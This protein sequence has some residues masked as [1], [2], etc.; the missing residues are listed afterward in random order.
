[1]K[2]AIVPSAKAKWEIREVKKPVVGPNQVLIKI[3]ASGLCYTDVHQTNGH[4]PGEFPRTLGHEP[5]G[6]IVELGIGVVNRK[7]GDR[8]GVPWI[9]ATCGRCEWCLSNRPMFCSNQIAT[10]M[11]LPGGHAEFMLAY[12]DATMLIPDNVSFEQA[13]PIFCAGYTVWSGL[14]WSDP[15]PHERIAVLGIGGLGHL[16]V[17][18]AKAAG[19]D[20][21]AIS[22]SSDK[23]KLI[24][25]LGADEIVRSGAELAK[26]GG[27]DIVLSTTNSNQAMVDSI[28]GLR[29]DGRFVAMG[30]DEKPLQI[31]MTDLIM[32]RIRIIGSQQNGSEYLYEALDMVS[33]GKVKVYTET[34]PFKEIQRAYE[35]VDKGEVRFRAVITYE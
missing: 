3:H 13:A 27:A 34:Y 23:D 25:E 9:Q 8:V 16:A 18:Y 7:I 21:I 33:K 11:Q 31:S 24:K 5:V 15:K 6:E 30:F 26:M 32:K 1:M 14:R 35:K 17:Q 12:A 28:A 10:G 19:F 2:A 22:H 29:P 4:L 20:T